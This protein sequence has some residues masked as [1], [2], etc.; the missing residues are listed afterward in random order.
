MKGR[1][2]LS[3]FDLRR[4]QEALRLAFRGGRISSQEYLDGLKELEADYREALQ[5]ARQ[6]DAPDPEPEEDEE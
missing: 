3:A 6:E 1:W 4:E 2:K 5:V